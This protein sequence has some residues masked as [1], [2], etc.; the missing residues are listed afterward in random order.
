MSLMW[1]CL[2][3]IQL[4]EATDLAVAIVFMAI[5]RCGVLQHI[6]TSKPSMTLVSWSIGTNDLA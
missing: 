6:N 1:R 5:S 4:F 3:L 2:G